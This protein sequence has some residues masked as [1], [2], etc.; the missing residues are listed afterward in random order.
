[1]RK[2]TTDSGRIIFQCK[3]CSHLEEGDADDTLMAEIFLDTTR[4]D[5]KH[6]VFVENAPHDL[7]GNKQMMDCGNC[8]RN[9]L[10]MIRIGVNEKPMF[11][12]P[13]GYRASVEQ[14]HASNNRRQNNDAATAPIPES[15]KK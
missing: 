2:T 8:G 3:A 1:M 5:L 7:A 4:D 10:T 9:Y 12:C 15:D 13:C 14:Y 6:A 11:S